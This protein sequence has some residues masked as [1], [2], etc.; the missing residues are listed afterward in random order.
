MENE[1]DRIQEGLLAIMPLWNYRITKPFKQLLDEGVSLEMYYAI[2]LLR[3]FGGSLTMAELTRCMLMPKQQMTKLVNR[4]E[5]GGFVTRALDAADR[6]SIRVALT[7]RAEAFIAEFLT[8]D[9]GYFRAMLER[10]GDGDRLAFGEAIATLTRVL[11]A[12]PRDWETEGLRR[13]E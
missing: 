7:D 9:A 10:M 3:W 8:K 4:L 13:G 11:A 5:E 2:Q 6:R 12:L 1:M